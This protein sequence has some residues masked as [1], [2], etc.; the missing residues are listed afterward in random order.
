MNFDQ[1]R[2]QMEDKSLTARTHVGFAGDKGWIFRIYIGQM[3]DKDKLKT[4]ARCMLDK[5]KT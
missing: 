4:N 2:G 1:V 3:L 5:C